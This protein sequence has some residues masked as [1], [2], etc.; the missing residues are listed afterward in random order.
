MEVFLSLRPV[1]Q[2]GAPAQSGASSSRLLFHSPSASLLLSWG[3]HDGPYGQLHR[4]LEV[5]RLFSSVLGWVYEGC[6]LELGAPIGH[7]NF[8][9]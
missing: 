3:T 1:I 9:S 6:Y 5:S 4:I 2:G 7:E 8:L